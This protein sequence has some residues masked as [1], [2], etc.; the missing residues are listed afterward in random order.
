MKPLSEQQPEKSGNLT[1][2]AIITILNHISLILSMHL[3]ESIEVLC[4]VISNSVITTYW[5]I[6]IMNGTTQFQILCD[7][8]CHKFTILA[9]KQRVVVLIKYYV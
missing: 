3:V 8:E 2:T 5:Y 6:N 1:L 9:Q 4:A 7:D